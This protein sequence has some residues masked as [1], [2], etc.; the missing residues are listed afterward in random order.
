[1][2]LPTSSSN[3]IVLNSSEDW[4]QWLAEVQAVADEAIWPH[5]DPDEPAPEQGLM[6]E[7]IRPDVKDFNQNASTY[8]QLN[9][10]LQKGYDNARKYYDLD[11]KYFH[12]QQ[13][14]LREVRKY[15][16][17]HV[18]PQ[19]KLL[20]DRS[21]SVRDWLVR[22]KE[23]TEPTK[24]YMSVKAHQQYT[25]SLKGLNR[26]TKISYW[27]DKWEHAMKLVEKYQL[28]QMG[29][30]IWLQDIAQAVRPLS[31]TLYMIYMDQ[32]N[33]PEKNKS[34][35]YRKV[36][37]KLREAFQNNSKRITTAR[38]SAFNADFAE[39]D[40]AGETEEAKGRDRSRSRKRAGTIIEE[41][42]SSSKKSKN[43][44]CPAC[45]IKGH[46][47]LDC[48]SIFENKRPEG[49]KLSEAITKR[50][51]ERLATDKG[52]A[53]EVDKLRLQEQDAIDEA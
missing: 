14:L 50:V 23:D 53:T 9:A 48:W 21:L 25:E 20:L 41:G 36:A 42:S 28:P 24:A 19:K 34:S 7:P 40:T 15:I 5:I 45:G 32:A 2:T 18:S 6:T 22:L 11:M 51:K 46:V 30:G 29:N 49:F 43:P 16:S 10:A 26:T 38:G 37:R 12:R 39:D 31:D 17:A 8:A 47:L 27:V 44:K 33:D 35:E 4:E 13:D 1:M 52:L 3:T